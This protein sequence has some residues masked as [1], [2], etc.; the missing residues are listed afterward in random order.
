[1]KGSSKKH[2]KSGALHHI[3]KADKSQRG[4]EPLDFCGVEYHGVAG[5]S[6]PCMQY[7]PNGSLAR[8]LMLL[9]RS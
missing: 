1:M 3:R 9:L 5:G 4:Y 6:F 8:S 7:D 2:A